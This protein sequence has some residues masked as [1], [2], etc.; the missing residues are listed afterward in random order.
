MRIEMS[1]VHDI[2]MMNFLEEFIR[3][4]KISQTPIKAMNE[5]LEISDVCWKLLEVDDSDEIYVVRSDQ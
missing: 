5:A 1:D 2:D 4:I 3:N